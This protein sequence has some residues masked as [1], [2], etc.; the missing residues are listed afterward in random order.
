MSVYRNTEA[1]PR[2]RESYTSIMQA[3]LSITPSPLSLSHTH[4]RA[5]IHI[6]AN[7]VTN[8]KLHK[9]KRRKLLTVECRQQDATQVEVA[10]EQSGVTDFP[11]LP[12]CVTRQ[13]VTRRSAHPFN[14]ESPGVAATRYKCCIF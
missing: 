6:Q 8:F 3:C 5:R 12:A 4:I 9:K 2:E 11:L 7:F 10:V 14:V 1:K 13:Y